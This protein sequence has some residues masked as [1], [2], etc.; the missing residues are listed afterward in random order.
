M[1]FKENFRSVKIDTMQTLLTEVTYYLMNNR[2]LS[3]NLCIICS[4]NNALEKNY[5]DGIC[6]YIHNKCFDKLN[7][8]IEETVREFESLDKNYIRGFFGAIIGSVLS[9]TLWVL[10]QLFLEN[11]QISILINIKNY[12]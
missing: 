7:N 2:I 11:R 3:K 5:I 8:E 1:K 4:E 6:Y 12:F 9:S 10:A